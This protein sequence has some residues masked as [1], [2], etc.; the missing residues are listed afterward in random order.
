MNPK[1]NPENL[2]RKGK[3]RPK[4]ALN[5]STRAKNDYFR[6]FFQLGGI[7]YLKNEL[8]ES[9][10]IRQRFLLHTL[11]GLMPKKADLGED[12]KMFFYEVAPIHKPENSGL[13]EEDWCLKT[14][15][16]T[17]HSRSFFQ[18]GLN[19]P[20]RGKWWR[21]DPVCLD[22]EKRSCKYR[23]D[24]DMSKFKP[25]QSG[26][27]GG[28]PRG[29][30]NKSTMAAQVLLDGE[31]QAL[32]RKA[33]KL[34]RAGNPV[35]L[36]LCLERILPP[37]KDRPISLKLPQLGGVQDIP[38]ALGAIVKAVAQGNLTPGEGQTIAAVLEAYRKGIELTDIEARLVALEEKTGHG[39]YWEK[40]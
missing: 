24:T 17:Y 25:G 19:D 13:G 31:A 8:K 33:I 15:V 9:K 5:K 36:R 40:A 32:T 12:G 21:S 18:R 34:A 28:R 16:T 2:T 26:N 30:L 39:K 6:A 11:P 4:G 27:P 35:A 3:G 38:K 22:W 37:R 10:R 14:S 7:K 20:L 29:A 1:G 23:R